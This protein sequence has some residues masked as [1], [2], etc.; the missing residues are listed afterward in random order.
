MRTQP[1]RLTPLGCRP[2][3][4]QSKTRKGAPAYIEH[5]GQPRSANYRSLR[6]SEHSLLYVL[7][8]RRHWGDRAFS[9]TAPNLLWIASPQ[10]LTLNSMTT[11]AFKVKVKTFI[12][13]WI[14]YTA[15]WATNVGTTLY[16]CHD[17]DYYDYERGFALNL[18]F[19]GRVVSLRVREWL[20][21]IASPSPHQCLCSQCHN[22]NAPTSSVVRRHITGVLYSFSWGYSQWR[23]APRDLSEWVRKWWRHP[24]TVDMS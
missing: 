4:Q 3:Y 6:S 7:R 21:S 13:S 10:F 23:K 11:A 16:K 17:Y 24:Q 15:L 14:F 2:V 9:V 1:Y 20:L 5:R 18:L 22:Q 19:L 12:F 8:P